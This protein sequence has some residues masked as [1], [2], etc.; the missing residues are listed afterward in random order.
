MHTLI[1]IIEMIKDGGEPTREE[2]YYT[3][4]ALEALSVFDGR[5]L[6]RLAEK[7]SKFITPQQQFEESWNRWKRAYAKSPKEWV[8]WD[9]DP[10]NP[11]RQKEREFH[12]KLY[13]KVVEQLKKE[14]GE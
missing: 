12:K 2:L 13:N 5:A 4:L 9:N 6:Q 3:V 11:E 1:E 8:G 7:E 14:K 10:H